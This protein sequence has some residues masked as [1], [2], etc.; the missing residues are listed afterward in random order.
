MR[1]SEPGQAEAPSE[2]R[3]KNVEALARRR[4]L[5]WEGGEP[6][7]YRQRAVIT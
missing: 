4:S 1:A 3:M 2:R 5:A 6:P 7:T